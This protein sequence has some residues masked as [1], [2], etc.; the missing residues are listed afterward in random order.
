MVTQFL[1]QVGPASRVHVQTGQGADD[2]ILEALNSRRCVSPPAHG[3]YTTGSGR[4]T[5]S[6]AVVN[7]S[8]A[9][10]RAASSAAPATV[11]R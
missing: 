8:Q 9:R 3:T 11:S 7:R 5:R 4:S 1:L 10:F 6:T 2:A